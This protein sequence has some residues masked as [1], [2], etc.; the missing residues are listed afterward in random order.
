MCNRSFQNRSRRPTGVAVGIRHRSTKR[1]R[2]DIKPGRR[3]RG[4]ININGHGTKLLVD[5]VGQTGPLG[6]VVYNALLPY[7]DKVVPV[8]LLKVLFLPF[9]ESLI[10][11]KQI[12]R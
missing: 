11:A 8:P 1:W 9:K 6:V 5:A 10:S 12:L 4:L 7:S 3:R 2:R